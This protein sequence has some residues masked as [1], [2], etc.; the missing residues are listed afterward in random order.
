MDVSVRPSKSGKSEGHAVVPK[1]VMHVAGNN[2]LSDTR[3]KEVDVDL[4]ILNDTVIK[5]EIA[6]L[7][8]GNLLSVFAVKVSTDL[9]WNNQTP[10]DKFYIHFDQIFKM[11]H[12]LPLDFNFLRLW[13]L[14][15]ARIVISI[16]QIQNVMVPDPY[17]FTELP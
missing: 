2:I 11:M 15:M 12:V 7:K 9:H 6:G 8:V 5:Q 3:Y 16:D 14:H 10:L 4:R 13:V 1:P 17:G